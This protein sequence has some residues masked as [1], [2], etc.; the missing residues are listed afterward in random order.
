MQFIKVDSLCTGAFIMEL[1]AKVLRTRRSASLH[2]S[3]Q[4]IFTGSGGLRFIVAVFSG[5]FATDSMIS[6]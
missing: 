4:A 3:K 2:Y 5:T 1:I 6:I